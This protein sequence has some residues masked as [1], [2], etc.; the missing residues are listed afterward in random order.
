MKKP[1]YGLGLLLCALL[2]V[3]CQSMT[4]TTADQDQGQESQQTQTET[5]PAQES[6]SEKASA[7]Y[8]PNSDEGLLLSQAQAVFGTL[9]E[10]M[11]G[12]ENDSPEKVALGEKLYHETAIS[13]NGTQSCN[14]CHPVEIGHAGADNRETGLGALGE[15]GDRND[16]P[17]YNAGFQF[18]QFW[19]GREPNLKEQA[20]GP[21]LNPV[22]MAM[23][24]EASVVDALKETGDYQAEFDAIYGDEGDESVT[25]DNFADAVATYERTLISTARF[26]DYLAGDIEA[27]DPRE[28]AGLKAFIDNQCIQCHTGPTIGGNMYQKMGVFHPYANTEDIGREDVTGDPKD[29]YFFKVPMLRNV[30][31]TAPYFHD[32]AVSSMAEAIDQMAYLQLDRRLDHR[33]IQDIMRF[34]VTLTDAEAST[35]YTQEDDGEDW[36]TPALKDLEDLSEE[37]QYGYELLTQTNTHEALAANVGNDLTCVSCHQNDGMKKF[38][39]PWVGVSQ[40]YPQYRGRENREV[41]LEERINGCFERSMN[42]TALDV[43]SPEMQAMVA[44]MD[45]V[46]QEAEKDQT[47]L[48]TPDYTPPDR[49]VDFEAGQARYTRNCMACHGADGQ[50]YVPM[51]AQDEGMTAIAAAPALWGPGSYNNG[52]GTN[53]VLTLAPFI[54]HN[55]PLGISWLEPLLSDDEVYDLAGYI[56]N[57]D[58]PQMEGLEEDY[59]D[60]SKKPVDAPYPPYDDDFSQEQHQFGPFQE[61]MDAQKNQ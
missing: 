47:G 34:M 32:G 22:E 5:R 11:P 20:K 9:P 28:Q 42:G 61:I 54:K 44:Y 51:S 8:D 26:D 39:L 12:G 58:R 33:T 38:G 27:L 14:S 3:S 2:L 29:K 25:F 23:P 53:R 6:R 21:V 59:P 60:L 7:T 31:L 19:D 46:S 50:G 55:M 48:G 56:N 24:D 40:S 43:E 35:Q 10:T 37:A 52:A 49:K 4:L 17:T 45:W 13:V 1:S 36:P 41:S 30:A 18:A 15:T 16:P 57:Q